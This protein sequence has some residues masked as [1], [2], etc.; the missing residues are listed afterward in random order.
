[1]SVNKCN[2]VYIPTCWIAASE[3]H[4]LKV[5]VVVMFFLVFIQTITSSASLSN[6]CVNQALELFLDIQPHAAATTLP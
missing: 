2:L 4:G 3:T 1:M 5:I 6:D